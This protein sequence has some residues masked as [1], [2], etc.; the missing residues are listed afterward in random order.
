MTMLYIL[1][2]PG[3]HTDPNFIAGWVQRLTPNA[4]GNKIIIEQ[5]LGFRSCPKSIAWDSPIAR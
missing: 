1:F 4:P 2:A 5:L 3:N